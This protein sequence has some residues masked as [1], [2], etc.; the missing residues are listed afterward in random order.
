MATTVPHPA[1]FLNPQHATL[2]L[3]PLISSQH[4][5]AVAVAMC[6]ATKTLALGMPLISVIYAGNP[7][8]GILALPLIVYHASQILQGNVLI[9]PLKK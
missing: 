6:G 1:M 5:D 2:T 8:A 3:I 7:S 9:G 4:P